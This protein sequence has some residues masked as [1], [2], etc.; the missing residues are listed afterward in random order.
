[1]WLRCYRQPRWTCTSVIRTS[2]PCTQSLTVPLELEQR[3]IGASLLEPGSIRRRFSHRTEWVLLTSGTTGGQAVRT[4]ATLTHSF[5]EASGDLGAEAVWSTFY[6]IRR[7]GGLQIL[8]R[9]LTARLAAAC[10]R[11]AS[12]WPIFSR[13]AP[14]RH[15]AHHRHAVALASALMSGASAQ[16]APRYVR[17]SGEIADQGI[18]DNLRALSRRRARARLRLDRG[19]ARLRGATIGQAGFP[20]RAYARPSPG[21]R[22]SG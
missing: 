9:A 4:L 8:L 11:A 14:P 2:P 6:D 16:I 21:C 19:R 5:A 17:L 1:M 18:L 3:L 10:A 13:C 20:R 22:G 7:Y 12:R 15:H